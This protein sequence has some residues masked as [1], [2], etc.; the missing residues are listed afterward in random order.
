MTRLF[1]L[2][3][4]L[5]L[6]AGCMATTQRR[7]DALVRQARM[8]NDDWRWARWDAMTSSMSKEDADAFRRRVEALEDELVLADFEV[9]SVTFASGSDQATV[10]SKFEWFLKRDPRV[11]VTTVEQRWEHRDGDWKVVALRRTRGDRFGLVTEP[12]ASPAAAAAG[13]GSGP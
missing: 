12:I 5:A 8:F 13:T 6:A 1:P 11:R 2:L 4:L 9:T 10:V 3:G 7:E